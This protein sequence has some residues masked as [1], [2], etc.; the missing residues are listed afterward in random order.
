MLREALDHDVADE[1]NTTREGIHLGAMAGTL[2]ILQRCY[3]GLDTRENVL[4]LN[5][6]LPDELPSLDLDIRYR[7]QWIKLHVD[8]TQ[9]TLEALP[10][11]AAPITIAIRDTRHQLTP[12]TTTTIPLTGRN[13]RS[14]PSPSPMPISAAGQ[15]KP[16]A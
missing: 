10:S 9:V 8:H 14:T 15:T 4:W 11:A 1:A 2:D 7:G 5:P 16:L 3:T 13:T 12:G 6:L